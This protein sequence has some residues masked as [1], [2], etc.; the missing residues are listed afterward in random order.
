MIS[1]EIKDELKSLNIL[2]V[3]DDEYVAKTFIKYLEK[4]SNK[5]FY[6]ENGEA[7]LEF[8]ESSKERVDIVITDINMPKLN[9]SSMAKAIKDKKPN[10]KVVFLT[11]HSDTAEI[12]EAINSGADGYI[13]K[14]FEYKN[15][16]ETLEMITK[17]ILQSQLSNFTNLPNGERLIGRLEDHSGTLLVV[18]LKNYSDLQAIYSIDDFKELIGVIVEFLD[19]YKPLETQLYHVAESKFAIHMPKGSYVEAEHCVEILEVVKEQFDF[20]INEIAFRPIFIYGVSTGSGKEQLKRAYM[21][22]EEARDHGKL[23]C[24][25]KIEDMKNIDKLKRNDFEII[26]KVKNALNN[27]DLVVCYQPIYDNVKKEIFS[28]ESLV[29]L[30]DGENHIAPNRFLQEAKKIGMLHIV[31]RQIINRSFELFSTK[32]SKN[33]SINLTE[34]DLRSDSLIPYLQNRA[35]TYNIDPSRVSFEVLESITISQ[36]SKIIDRIFEIQSLGFKISIDDFGAESSNFSR[37]IQIHANYLK[38]D[39]AFI[40]DIVTDVDSYKITAA[41]TNFAK[42]MDLKVIAEFVH[43]K[44]VLE[45]VTKLGIDYSQGYFLGKPEVIPQERVEI[46]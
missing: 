42:S 20:E 18:E 22:L 26:N 43:S 29:R 30:R 10:V 9:G 12:I 40:K 16:D 23:S 32:N 3:E 25:I 6:K 41:I 28:Y 15:I 21:A 7:G 4:I 13:V 5:V 11:A 1:K 14:P 31:T 19:L 8:F 2:Y 27:N 35:K 34:D 38:I 17:K 45:V 46:L 24:T 36:S 44:E 33:F 37:L 39:G